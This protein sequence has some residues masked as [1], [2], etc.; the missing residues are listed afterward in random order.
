[1]HQD[2]DIEYFGIHSA[3]AEIPELIAETDA[4]RTRSA[5]ETAVG[6]HRF[7]RADGVSDLN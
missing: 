7:E 3:A 2:L 6:M 5:K 4:E 1:M